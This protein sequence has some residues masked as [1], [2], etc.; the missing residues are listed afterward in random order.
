MATSLYPTPKTSQQRLE[1]DARRQERFKRQLPKLPW[2]TVPLFG[3]VSTGLVIWFIDIVPGMW[4]AGNTAFIFFTFALWLFFGSLVLSWVLF[5]NKMLYAFA[6]SA[7]VFWFAYSIVLA[8]SAAVYTGV[9]AKVTTS[10]WLAALEVYGG[11]LL[12]L[13][14]I[15]FATARSAS[16]H[17]KGAAVRE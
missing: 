13:C 9:P 4:A 1:D 16:P 17:K 2:L 15:V 8:L 14:L 12:V 5:T 6:R 3:V 10:N 11:A 7:R